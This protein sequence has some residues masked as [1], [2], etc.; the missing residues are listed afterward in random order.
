MV[1][2]GHWQYVHAHFWLQK[3]MLILVQ[4]IKSPKKSQS[5]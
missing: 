4:E 3:S 5:S 2:Y 1:V